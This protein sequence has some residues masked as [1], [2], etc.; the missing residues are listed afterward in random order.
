MI[1]LKLFYFISYYGSLTDS[2][3]FCDILRSRRNLRAVDSY[4]RK[5]KCGQQ[6][7]VRNLKF[8][9]QKHDTVLLMLFDCQ[10][11]FALLRSSIWTLSPSWQQLAILSVRIMLGDRTRPWWTSAPIANKPDLLQSMWT[12]KNSQ[13]CKTADGFLVSFF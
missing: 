3:Q 9:R 5:S 10:E 2:A 12:H 4:S 11:I 6:Y 7:A 1:F 13:M 8:Q